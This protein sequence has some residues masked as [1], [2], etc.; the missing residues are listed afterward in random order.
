MTAPPSIT[1]SSTGESLAASGTWTIAFA[2][3]LEALVARIPA[4]VHRVE[5]DIG[6]VERLDS[7]GAWLLEKQIRRWRADG[8]QAELTS[9]PERFRGLIDE[10]AETNLWAPSM[11][12][13]RSGPIVWI[14]GI[15][16]VASR[17]ADEF[18]Q[19]TGMLGAL[20]VALGRA[21]AR[22]RLSRLTSIVHQIDRVGWHATGMIFLLTFLI[23]CILSQQGI[24]SLRR[25]GAEEFFV[26]LVEVL[27]L[28]EIGVLLVAI[29]VA[30]R[31]G[32]SY[33]AELGSMKMREEVD[34]LRAMGVDPVEVLMLPRIV[35]LVIALPTLTFLG[36]MAALFGGGLVGWLYGGLSPLF[37]VSRLHDAV[38][39]HDFFV[40]MIK[41]PV[42]ALVVGIIAC[43]EGMRVQGSAESLGR[44]TTSSVVKSVFMVIVLDGLFAM[45]F[46]AIGW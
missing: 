22:P 41:A 32:S 17:L 38:S 8:R 37:F 20:V 2:G 42:M 43:T 36:L 23:G 30:G 39:I 44:R 31:S 18:V 9:V 5:I 40:G 29:M 27:V 21:I 35:A 7:F 45:F 3:E 28:R 11:A 16:E 12:H 46:A 13:R 24:Y 14:E 15:G 34:A 10:I 33:T 1:A 19:F 4:P 25:F 26:N 6:A